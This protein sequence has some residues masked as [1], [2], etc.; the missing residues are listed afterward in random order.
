MY[1]LNL[2][3][4]DEIPVHGGS[5]R[6]YASHISFKENFNNTEEYVKFEKNDFKLF[7][8]ETYIEFNLDVNNIKNDLKN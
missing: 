8:D 3:K 2:F 5:I 1:E 6:G 7:S 4:I